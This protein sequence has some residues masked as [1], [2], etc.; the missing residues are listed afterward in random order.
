MRMNLKS[1]HG[2]NYQFCLL[3]SL[4]SILCP[5]NSVSKKVGTEPQQ[6]ILQAHRMEVRVSYE[7]GPLVGAAVLPQCVLLCPVPLPAAAVN[8]SPGM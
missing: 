5:T 4:D 2:P 1:C 6:G 7:I 8:P 3:L